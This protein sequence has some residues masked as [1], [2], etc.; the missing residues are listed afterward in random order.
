MVGMHNLSIAFPNLVT[1]A[2]P[3]LCTLPLVKWIHVL[4]VQGKSASRGR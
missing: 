1:V 4:P 2:Q 3:S